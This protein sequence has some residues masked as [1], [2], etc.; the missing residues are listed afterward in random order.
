MRTTEPKYNPRSSRFPWIHSVS[1]RVE[2]ADQGESQTCACNPLAG[3]GWVPAA[4]R[5]I[6]A[7]RGPV[8]VDAGCPRQE[9]DEQTQAEGMGTSKPLAVEAT[10]SVL[11]LCS[12]PKE[13]QN[14][15][16]T[17]KKCQSTK[18]TQNGTSLR[19]F[20][21][22][23]NFLVIVGRFDSEIFTRLCP[24]LADDLGGRHISFCVY[25]DSGQD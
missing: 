23:L 20:R 10:M 4:R 16:A 15:R 2:R 12:R 8:E 21:C 22:D 17:Q 25:V 11:C 7:T 6:F 1:A 13:S 18:G 14:T 5:A 9:S 3:S 24:L 19:I